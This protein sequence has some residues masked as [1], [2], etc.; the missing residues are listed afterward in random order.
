VSRVWI[1]G[2]AAVTALGDDADAL[3]GGLLAGTSGIEPVER[4]PTDAYKSHVAACVP[5]LRQSGPGSLV[6]VLL[7]RLCGQLPPL[8]ADTRLIAATT[9]GGGD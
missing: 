3:W 2:T 1:V 7:D 8:P 5:G 9:K 4:F 6:N